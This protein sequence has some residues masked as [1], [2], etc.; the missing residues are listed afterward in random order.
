M[1]DAVYTQVIEEWLRAAE[2]D[3]E[4]LPG[5]AGALHDFY[6]THPHLIRL[7]RWHALER[8][9]AEM[10][11][12]SVEATTDKLKALA[13]AQAD[14]VID[15]GLPPWAVLSLASAWSDAS[16]EAGPVVT[17]P[18]HFATQRHCVVVSVARLSK[19]QR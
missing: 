8:P 17:D 9:H 11:P 1:F 7:A 3:A 2:F 16:P 14:G 15:A 6:R 12:V 13:R 18:E 5:Y 4:D 19:P 10:L